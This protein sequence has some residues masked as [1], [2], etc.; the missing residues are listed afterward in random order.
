[1]ASRYEPSLRELAME[2]DEERRL[3]M[4]AE[5]D[6]DAADLDERWDNRDAYAGLEAE[7]DRLAAERDDAIADRD[8][9]KDATRTGSSIPARES[10]TARTSS[11]A[12]RRTSRRNPAREASRRCG[13]TGST[14][15]GCTC[16]PR[17]AP[18]RRKRRSTRWR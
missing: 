7:R 17:Q 1:M 13:T 4:A 16:L 14:K 6:R 9:W 3:E 2:P 12:T 5:I 8:S 10:P 15:G 18:C 11:T